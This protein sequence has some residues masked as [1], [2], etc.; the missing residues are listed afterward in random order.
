MNTLREEIIKREDIALTNVDLMK[1]TNGKTKIVIYE[2]LANMNAL[3]FLNLF[4]EE[5][6]Y[7]IILLYQLITSNHW[8]TIIYRNG[9]LYHW[10]SYGLQPDEELDIIHHGVKH[11]SRIYRELRE[12]G[13]KIN[14]NK[15]RFQQFKD[16]V[17]TCGRWAANR[18]IHWNK[19]NKEY[20]HYFKGDVHR[21]VR[22]LDDII[23]LLTTSQLNYII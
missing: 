13:V 4:K 19:T 23:V 2:D 12:V 5:T 7:N 21:L 20:V 8:I 1:I 10:D 9:V 6:N 18:S 16:H 3:D 14:V 15:Y 22:S 11:L 17:S